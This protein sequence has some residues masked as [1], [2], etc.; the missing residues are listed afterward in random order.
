MFLPTRVDGHGEAFADKEQHSTFFRFMLWPQAVF[1][2]TLPDGTAA[3]R[4]KFF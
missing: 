1:I 3:F 2:A 4:A